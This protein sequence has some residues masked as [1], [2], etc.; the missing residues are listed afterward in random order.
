MKLVDQRD[1][2]RKVVEL[3]REGLYDLEVYVRSPKFDNDNKVNVN[4][5]TLRINELKRLIDDVSMGV[6]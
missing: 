4:D 2:L 1:G 5:I 3:Y 6:L